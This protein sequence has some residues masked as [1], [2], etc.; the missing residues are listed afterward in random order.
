MAQKKPTVTLKDIAQQT[1]YSI[2]TVS[3]ALRDKADIA[4]ATRQKIK[5]VAAE[6]GH[7]NNMLAASLR[8]GY[9][10]TVAVIL[11][12]ISNP[13]FAIMMKEIEVHAR[14]YGYNS[15]LYNTNE[16]EELE[17][18][19]IRSALNKNVDGIIICP[20]QKTQENLKYLE[21]TGVPFVLIGR[22]DEA[23]SYVVCNDE[24][25]GFLAT[26]ALISAGHRDILLLHGA[27]YISSAR[28]RL[29]GYR[30]AY[31]QS[32]LE[33]PEGL[34]REVPVT[35]NGCS[36]VLE[37]LKEEGMTFSAIFAFSDMLAWEA[38]S[39][40]MRREIRVPQDCSLIGFDHIQSRLNLP[41]SLTSVSS[42]KGRMSTA[43]VDLLVRRMHGSSEKE[44]LVIDTAL[45]VGQTV[46]TL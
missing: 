25:G 20:A 8:L 17:L 43:A 34:I 24:M 27:M 14:E 42:Y 12:D 40:L 36:A 38:W 46:M 2:N 23:Y 37:Q 19:A 22:R 44:Q 39:C 9:T 4:D 3:R 35:A 16:D 13:H 11:G 18:E 15:I 33:V 10:N 28:E 6:M 41:F 7:V 31:A 32:G 5:K 30:R 1:G 29:A 26:A 21:S 45:A